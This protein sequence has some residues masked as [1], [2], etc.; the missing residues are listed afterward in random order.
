VAREARRM[1]PLIIDPVSGGHTAL[2]D[3]QLW[4]GRSS[5]RQQMERQQMEQQQMERQLNL[6][7]QQMEQQL[8][9]ERQQMEQQLKLERQQ[10]E[11]QQMERQLNLER[12]K[13]Q[14]QQME[15][16]RRQQILCSMQATC[17]LNPPLPVSI[18]A[19]PYY[20]GSYSTH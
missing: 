20:H 17:G 6:E 3:T 12:Q 13:L 11:Q 5:R 9:L 7:R 10:M 15:L 19:M 4:T 16:E 18:P 8:N 2:S 1:Q 14:R